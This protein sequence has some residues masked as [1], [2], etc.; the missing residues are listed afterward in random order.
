MKLRRLLPLALVFALA[1]GC[2]SGTQFTQPTSGRPLGKA[3]TAPSGGPGGKANQSGGLDIPAADWQPCPDVYKGIFPNPPQNVNFTCATVKVPKDWAHP[4]DG[5]TYDIAMVRGRSTTQRDRVGS[6]FINPGGPGGSGFEYGIYR[7]VFLPAEIVRRFDIIGFDP[8]GVGRSSPVK[9]FSDADLDQNFGIDPDPVS[10][11]GFQSFVTLTRNL[12]QSC[13]TKY[14]D[15]LRLFSTEQTARDLDA[16]RAAVG[17][18]QLTYLGYSY[19][20]LLGAV[21]A[22]LFPKNVRALVLDGA[23]DPTQSMQESAEKQAA[24]FELAFTNFSKWCQSNASSCPIGPDAR[25]VVM[26]AIADARAN[27]V[28]GAGGR[29]ATSG[30]V[31]TAVVSSLYSESS[32]RLLAQAMDDLRNGK[33]ARMFQLA[34]SYAERDAN[35]KYSNMFDANSA[36]NC[37]DSDDTPTVEQDRTLQ[38]QWRQKYPLFGG[39]LALNLI[40][41]Q[42]P[43]KRDPYPTGAATGSAPIVVIGTL[44]DPATP[45]EQAPAL[46]KMLGVGTLVTWKGEGHTAYPQTGCIIDAVNRYFIDLKVPPANTTCE[47]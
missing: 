47:K 23:V 22:Q 25:A 1:A 33:P 2:T 15:D 42:W 45:Y 27:P 37:A 39:P 35:G 24:G 11:E 9:C 46:A 30:W 44:G 21:Y 32:W 29:K 8:R 43:G 5:G 3:S 14:G 26:K 31:F 36:V 10:D 6:L 41:A 7:S 19:G 17:E 34:D 4:K 12:A 18:P 28:T 38:S 40:C 20:T 16:L 13:G